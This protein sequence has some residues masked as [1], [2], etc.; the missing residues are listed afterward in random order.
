MILINYYIKMAQAI[1][2]KKEKLKQLR[3]EF[4]RDNPDAQFGHPDYPL[5]FRKNTKS[6]SEGKKDLCERVLR[7]LPVG[8]LTTINGFQKWFSNTLMPKLVGDYSN[9]MILNS[10]IIAIF[11]NKPLFLHWVLINF[12]E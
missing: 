5:L 6:F 1:L 11:K 2:S 3:N 7:V 12:T 4:K 10:V 8:E 9:E